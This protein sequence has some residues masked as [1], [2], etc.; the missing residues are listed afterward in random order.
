MDIRALKIFSHLARTLH[1]GRTSR[2][3][4]LTPSA[5]TRTIQ[6]LEDEVGAPLFRRDNRSVALTPAGAVFRRY[7]EEA[8]ERWQALQREL[9][10]SETLNG[11]ISLFCSVTAAMFILPP[12]L[13]AFRQAHPGVQI[14]LQTG[15]AAEALD[16]LNNR[17]A[18]VTIAALPERLPPA[19]VFVELAL[20]PLVFIAPADGAGFPA[21]GTDRIDWARIPV[22]LAERGLS[23]ERIDR[24]F[25]ANNIRPNIYAEVAGNEALLAMVS[26]GCGVGVVPELVL[27]KSPL[28]EQVRLFEVD[29]GLAPFI[30]GACTL[31]RHLRNPVIRALWTT[32]ASEQRER[33]R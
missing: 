9:A 26:L 29:S 27:E 7:A 19:V 12:M 15:D 10:G 22:I 3:C 14:K 17:E 30:I 32:M 13:R 1:F 8:V 33:P 18:E 5:L 25:R 2:A 6:R 16:R 4:N 20:T 23:R 24:W 31:E 21:G 11:E 28:R